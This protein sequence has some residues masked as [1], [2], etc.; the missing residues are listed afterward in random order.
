MK[1]KVLYL[2]DKIAKPSSGADQVNRRN[3]QLLE[4]VFNVS[5]LSLVDGPLSNIYLSCTDKFLK[6]I[7]FS[8]KNVDF[9]YVFIQQK[10]NQG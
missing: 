1:S 5:Y 10:Q 9:E 3:Q 2:G 8:M 7:D 6:S 4:S